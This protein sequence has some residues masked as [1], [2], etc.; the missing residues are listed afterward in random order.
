MS[1]KSLKITL[2]QAV[3]TTVG[4]SFV[5]LLAFFGGIKSATSSTKNDGLNDA[6]DQI[7]KSMG[8]EDFSSVEL[9]LKGTDGAVF[10][11]SYDFD[12]NTGSVTQ[13]DIEGKETQAFMRDGCVNMYAY[14]EDGRL[15]HSVATDDSGRAVTTG[16]DAIDGKKKSLVMDKN[17]QWVEKK[18]T[19]KETGMFFTSPR[20]GK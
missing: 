13:K 6:L 8:V 15:T 3:A 12:K 10:D 16:I 7:R 5:A 14:D 9:K 11:M 17:G 4:T 20:G 19:S 18:L 1:L 2:A